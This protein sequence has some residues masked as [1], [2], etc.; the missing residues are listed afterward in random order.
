LTFIQR[1]DVAPYLKSG[2]TPGDVPSVLV[3]SWGRGDPQKDAIT[4][5]FLDS[6]GRLREHSKIDN[7]VDSGLRD[8]FTDLLKRRQ[9]N[10]IVVGGFSMATTKLAQRVKEIVGGNQPVLPESQGWGNEPPPLPLSNNEDS[11]PVIYVFDEVAR[12]YQ[13][14]NRAID[15]FSALSPTAKY[16]VGLARYAQSP[17]NEYAALGS[18]ITAISF[19]EDDQ[20]L[21]SSSK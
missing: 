15:E 1:I 10:L 18:D 16:C 21:V 7:L 5:V 3:V 20:H 13:H 14:S 9:P 19:E 8:E 2:L 11:P 4:L 6:A 17:L 12:I